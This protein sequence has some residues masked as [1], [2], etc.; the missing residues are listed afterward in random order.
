VALLAVVGIALG[1]V[2]VD[3]QQLYGGWHWPALGFAAC[4]C[5]IAVFGPVWILGLT[6]RFD[7]PYRYTRSL[8]RTSYPAFILQTPVLIGA[9]VALRPLGVPAEIKALLVAGIGVTAAFALASLLLRAVPAL[10][11]VL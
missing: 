10:S 8:A 1:L 9:A 6:Q 7:R 11:R 3:D 5:L 2:G 4:E